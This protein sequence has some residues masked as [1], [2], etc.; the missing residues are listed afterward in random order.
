MT[1]FFKKIFP[2]KNQQ[3]EKQK[4]KT[5]VLPDVLRKDSIAFDIGAN[6]GNITQKMVDNGA[7]IYAFEPNPYAYAK[8]RERFFDTDNVTCYPKAVFDKATTVDLY[9]HEFSDDDEVKWSVG[10]SL[11][12]FKGN[13]VKE[14][15]YTVETV[16]LSKF[17]FELGEQIDLIKM[18][19]EGVECRIINHLIDTG[20]IDRVNV[21]L[22]ETHDHK[23]PELKEE[24]D[25][26]RKRIGEL[27]LSEKINL[28]WI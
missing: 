14:K 20:A 9:F 18:D 4:V 12:D 11:L 6:I 2:H 5:A 15:K 22:V 1:K 8:L 13:V 10:S 24:T 27:G 21:M 25:A 28:N 16:D 17:I 19:V 3:T 23:I 26:L 7:K